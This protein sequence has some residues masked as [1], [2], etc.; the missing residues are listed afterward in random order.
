M[1]LISA[2]YTGVS[3]LQTYGDSLQ[4]IGDNIANVNTTAYKSSR[5]EF[6]D[7]LNQSIN[8]ASGNSQIGRGVTLSRIS[9]DYAQGSFSNT[10]RMT[11]LAINGNGF[12]VVNNGSRNFYTR[13]GQ[14]SIN[15][16]GDLVTSG[17]LE[18]QGRLYQAGQATTQ[19]G[20]IN[21]SSAA[22]TPQV[23]GS[24][25]PAG[26]GICIAANF[27][28]ADTAKT[29]SAADPANTSNLSTS[30]SVYDSLGQSH[31]VNIYFNKSAGTANTWDFHALVDGGELTGGTAGTPSETASGTLTFDNSGNLLPAATSLTQ[32]SFPFK[33][34]NAQ[35]IGFSFGGSTQYASSSAIQSQSQDGYPSGNLTSVGVGEDGVIT[36]TFSNGRIMPI[37]QVMLANFSNLQGLHR[38]GGGLLAET[39]DSGTP[40]LGEPGLGSTGSIASYSLELSNVDLANEFVNLISTQRAYQANSKTI[41]TGDQL[42]SEAINLIK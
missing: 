24:G 13:N 22:S 11:D 34:V 3:G 28:A 27:N 6:A 26:S 20:T 14:F 21:V 17:G 40:L 8:V 10:D 25:T 41:T 15:N 1:S 2:L 32:S 9:T 23:T 42:I 29:F 18:L 19:M 31:T 16:N 5:A 37:G 38:N 7:V 35:K 36:G 39:T 30:L 33:G 12:F 4:T